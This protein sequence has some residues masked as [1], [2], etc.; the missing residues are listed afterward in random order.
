MQTNHIWCYIIWNY[1]GPPQLDKGHNISHYYLPPWC[2]HQKQCDSF[3]KTDAKIIVEKKRC[4]KS[5][6]NNCSLIFFA[7]LAIHNMQYVICYKNVLYN[8]SVVEG[9]TM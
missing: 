6:V 5:T 8:D 7:K 3:M 9:G 4:A 2:T 1:D